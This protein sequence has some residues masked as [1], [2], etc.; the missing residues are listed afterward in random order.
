M[1]R[2]KRSLGTSDQDGIVDAL[3]DAEQSYRRIRVKAEQAAEIAHAKARQLKTAANR[4]SRLSVSDHGLVEKAGGI[5]GLVRRSDKIRGVS[6]MLKFAKELGDDDPGI[7]Y[8]NTDRT[9]GLPLTENGY[10]TDPKII[11]RAKRELEVDLA[12][13]EDDAREAESVLKSLGFAVQ[14]TQSEK[15]ERS[16]PLTRKTTLVE[17]AR[18]YK[19]GAV[20]PHTIDALVVVAKQFN[21]LHGDPDVRDLTSEHYAAYSEALKTAPNETQSEVKG[22]PFKEKLRLCRELGLKTISLRTRRKRC[23]YIKMLTEQAKSTGVCGADPFREQCAPELPK[24]GKHS[25][26]KAHYKPFTRDEL[27]RLVEAVDEKWA[28]TGK[29]DRVWAFYLL[30]YHGCRRSEICQLMVSDIDMNKRTM[31]LT[32]DGEGDDGTVQMIKS[33]SSLRTIPIHDK[34]IDMGFLDFVAERQKNSGRLFPSFTIDKHGKVGSSFSANFTYLLRENCGITEA[35][36]VLHSLRSTWTDAARKA[37]ILPEVRR[38]IAGRSVTKDDV[39]NG[40]GDGYPVE[41]MRYHLNHVDPFA[42]V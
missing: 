33:D 35:G 42:G 41:Q 24:R 4:L 22:K 25:K 32:D 2:F 23:T 5:D 7:V 10:E 20:A 19:D 14:P 28:K 17:V 39:E 21:E 15:S 36:K 8:A 37:E 40:Y 27:G 29:I 13:L 18:T 38:A 34:L 3:Y 31:K 6:N 11:R 12:E 9:N 1:T 26:A 16:G 30:A